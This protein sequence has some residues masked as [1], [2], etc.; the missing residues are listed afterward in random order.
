[1]AHDVV[2]HV[3]VQFRLSCAAGLGKVNLIAIFRLAG[4]PDGQVS[5][6]GNDSYFLVGIRPGGGNP[7]ANLLSRGQVFH[8]EVVVKGEVAGILGDGG[9]GQYEQKQQNRKLAQHKRLPFMSST[10]NR[11]LGTENRLETTHGRL[12]GNAV[13]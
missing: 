4:F 13:K 5:F 9:E 1:M 10:E 12:R 3:E 11:E 8:G 7:D 2:F 6:S